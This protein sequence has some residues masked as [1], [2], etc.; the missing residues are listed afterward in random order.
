MYKIE[1]MKAVNG[2]ILIIGCRTYVNEDINKGCQDLARFLKDPEGVEKEYE[3]RY[4][5]WRNPGPT[6]GRVEEEALRPDP[7]MERINR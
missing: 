1:V 4:P 7:T 2:I 5:N 3:V 6:V